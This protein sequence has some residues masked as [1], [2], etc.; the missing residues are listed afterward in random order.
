VQ[1]GATTP[2][3]HDRWVVWCRG[4]LLFP[5]HHWGASGR[6][7]DG[8]TDISLTGASASHLCPAKPHRRPVRTCGSV[9]AEPVVELRGSLVG[10]DGPTAMGLAMVLVTRWVRVQSRRLGILSNVRREA[11]GSAGRA[12]RPP[13]ARL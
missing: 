7:H 4:T 3:R 1:S 5:Y 12:A 6:H 10:E 11:A 8:S 9:G 2:S 13:I